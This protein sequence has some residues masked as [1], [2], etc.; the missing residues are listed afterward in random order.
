[1]IEKR[2]EERG[3]GG[4]CG[5]EW[6]GKYVLIV[7]NVCVP[8]GDRWNSPEVCC[9]PRKHRNGM[10]YG[11]KGRRKRNVVFLGNNGV[12]NSYKYTEMRCIKSVNIRPHWGREM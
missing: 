6:R 9:V 8:A 10:G 11:A 1:M 12:D 5:S 4:E 2:R 7:C 3:G